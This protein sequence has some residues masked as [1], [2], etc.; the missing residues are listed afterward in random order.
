[1]KKVLEFYKNNL[2]F[3]ILSLLLLVFFEFVG[4]GKANAADSQLKAEI[5]PNKSYVILE[6]SQIYVKYATFFENHEQF[7]I[8][9]FRIK[10]AGNEDQV[11]TGTRYMDA[12][13][14]KWS[15]VSASI[16]DNGTA[17][18]TVRL[19]WYGKNNDPARKITHEVSIFPNSRYLKI[20]Y[21]N[22]QYGI[23]IVDNAVPGG[24]SAGKHVAYGH[25]GWL[26]DYITHH[27]SVAKGSYYNRYPADGVNDPAN[28]GSLNYNGNFIVG[29]YNPDN[30]RGFARTMPV[31]AIS[32]LKLLFEPN[33]RRGLE[34]FPY[35]FLKAHPPFT[36]Y[37]F[38]VTGGESEIL[39]AG[40]ALAN[41]IR[42]HHPRHP[43]EQSTI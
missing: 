36:G 10:S 22:V 9:E 26:R 40:K 3:V 19:V 37:L 11:G 28:G 43:R 42:Y 32:I 24:T 20:D 31:S 8:R 27:S 39:S 12:G 15:L 17:K 18:K 1:M 7:G 5:G 4:L 2:I 35:P 16:V 23:N 34:M 38:V 14:G 25:S 21:L 30:G 41:G 6:N 13:A 29:V 33:Q